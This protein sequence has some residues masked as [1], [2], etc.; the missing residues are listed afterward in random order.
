MITQLLQRIREKLLIYAVLSQTN[1]H[2]TLKNIVLH[3][4]LNTTPLYNIQICCTVLYQILNRI[5]FRTLEYCMEIAL[6]YFIEIYQYISMEGRLF[7]SKINA[8]N[9]NLDLGVATIL[10]FTIVKPTQ[11]NLFAILIIDSNANYSCCSKF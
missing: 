1:I 6:E 8:F 2:N 10:Q 5:I 11:M 7:A 4:F 3:I 9:F